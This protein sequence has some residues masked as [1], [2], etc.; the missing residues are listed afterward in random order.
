MRSPVTIILSVPPAYADHTHSTNFSPCAFFKFVIRRP[1]SLSFLPDTHLFP[2]AS[3]PFLSFLSLL[4]LPRRHPFSA[5]QFS[6]RALSLARDV[7]E[8]CF[9]H[10]PRR[11]ASIPKSLI[12]TATLT[13]SPP[14]CDVCVSRFTHPIQSSSLLLD[15]PLPPK[16]SSLPLR[17]LSF[18]PF[19]SSLSPLLRSRSSC[20]LP[21][22]T[23]SRLPPLGP[24][25]LALL[26]CLARHTP[27]R[28]TYCP[29]SGLR[30][31]GLGHLATPPYH[32]YSDWTSADSP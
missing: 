20:I 29:T 31:K 10:S 26:L 13:L 17:L 2:S 12:A 24:N 3:P 25:C 15:W 1:I 8:H 23:P 22:C 27:P 5:F 32:A 9:P 7:P 11:S 28:S 19:P 16:I 4:L 30:S 14:P 6:R 18:P 21:L